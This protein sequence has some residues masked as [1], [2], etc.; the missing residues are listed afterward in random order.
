MAWLIL[1]L[2]GIL[3]VIWAFAMKLSQGFTRPV[4]A[5]ITITAMVASFWLLVLC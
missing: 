4:P 5:F 1:F 2:A 3:E